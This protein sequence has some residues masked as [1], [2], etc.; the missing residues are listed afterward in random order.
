MVQVSD[1]DLKFHAI[2]LARLTPFGRAGSC[3]KKPEPLISDEN[4]S[5]DEFAA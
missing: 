4:L 3:E 1:A 2:G 5:Y